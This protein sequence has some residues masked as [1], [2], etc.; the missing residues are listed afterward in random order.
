MT[1]SSTLDDLIDG[2]SGVLYFVYKVEQ[3]TSNQ[4]MLSGSNLKLVS[5]IAG[6]ADNR[7]YGRIS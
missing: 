1:S 7:F 5:D 3:V 6:T 4:K 2:D